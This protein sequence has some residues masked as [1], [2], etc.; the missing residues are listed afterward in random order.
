MR[1]RIECVIISAIQSVHNYTSRLCE[2]W[3]WNFEFNQSM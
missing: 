1:T 3:R 2:N